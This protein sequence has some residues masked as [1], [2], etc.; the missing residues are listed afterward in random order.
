MVSVIKN[1]VTMA[2]DVK[3]ST[4]AADKL[5]KMV[6]SAVKIADTSSKL[7]GGAASACV[8]LTKLAGQLKI[9]NGLVGA[10]N[11]INRLFEW[12]VPKAVGVGK[13]RKIDYQWKFNKKQHGHKIETKSGKQVNV[14]KNVYQD[15]GYW[16]GPKTFSQVFTT[17]A[18]SIE[19]VRFWEVIGLVTF[20][21]LSSA[22]GIAKSVVYIP[23]ATLGI[24]AGGV[25]LSDS[26]KHMRNVAAKVDRWNDKIGGSDHTNFAKVK[27]VA[28]YTNKKKAAEDVRKGN[29]NAI[30]SNKAKKL[31]AETRIAA[32]DSEV[33]TNK[34][35]RSTKE[36]EI[37]AKKAGMKDKK[38]S[39]AEKATL[40]KEIKQLRADIK[41]TYA[42]DK[43]ILREK[44]K[45]QAEIKVCEKFDA[46]QKVALTNQNK[47]IDGKIKKYDLFITE[48][49]KVGNGLKLENTEFCKY[50]EEKKVE[51]VKR[52]EIAKSNKKKVNTKTWLGIA[53]NVGK[54]ALGVIG[55]VGLAVGIAT[56][57]WFVLAVAVGWFATYTF[58]FTKW[59]YGNYNKPTT[60][61]KPVVQIKD[62]DAKLA[63]ATA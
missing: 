2:N 3:N 31:G 46:N 30:A 38:K 8:P 39:K 17:I 24:T 55:L 14:Q 63:A 42:N 36:A 27:W 49:Q 13:D 9:F 21:A 53:N 6:T 40:R 33:K 26:S 18:H 12:V 10:F 1:P 22:L 48:I 47:V 60:I 11:W 29:V 7:A 37:S 43:K 45:L 58:G 16:S 44:K 54:L 20:G 35:T 57:P 50:G 25:T 62:I 15:D 19:F 34:T 28:H 59:V 41:A 32:I 51:W 23:A 56:N 4:E 61:V 5:C 52:T